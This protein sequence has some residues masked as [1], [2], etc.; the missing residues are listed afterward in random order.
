M[1]TQQ[2]VCKRDGKTMYFIEESEKLS[3]GE[4]RV[5]FAYKCLICGYK[6]N[7][8]QAVIEKKSNGGIIVK[9]RIKKSP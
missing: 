2:Y 1:T 6:I 8:E 9:R 4:Y 5:V 7:V 3:N